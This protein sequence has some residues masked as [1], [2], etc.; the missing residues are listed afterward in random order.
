MTIFATIFTYN[1]M[2][3]AFYI[4]TA[5]ALL[6]ATGCTKEDS[7]CPQDYT[8]NETQQSILPPPI[9]L[10]DNEEGI[11]DNEF[12]NGTLPGV[13]RLSN[14]TIRFSQGNLQYQP[15]TGKYRFATEQ[16]HYIGG[17]RCP[18]NVAYNSTPCNNDRYRDT[19][20]TGWI[21][22]FSYGSSGYNNITPTD[23][24]NDP[25]HYAPN[26]LSIANN[27]Y[28]WGKYNNIDGAELGGDSTWHTMTDIE[29]SMLL[30]YNSYGL[31][32]V[33]NVTGI[34]IV[35]INWQTPE[36]CSFVANRTNNTYNYEQWQKM[37]LAG[38]VFLPAAGYRSSQCTCLSGYNAYYWTSSANDYLQANK[39]NFSLDKIELAFSC[40][41]HYR[42][43]V[44]LV[45]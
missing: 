32:K 33:C 21:D 3:K 19:S 11:V 2:K 20:Y 31:A 44:R 17:N 9:P 38:A 8:H 39:L 12:A 23:T 27:S 22:L 30:S 6:L 10:G 14:K 18:G 16:Y 34:V 15:S 4:L 25:A 41:R 26:T 29:W 1:T 35:P 42:M 7:P 36:G 5:T 43:A 24:N 40:Y 28:D 13:F 37:E 45:K